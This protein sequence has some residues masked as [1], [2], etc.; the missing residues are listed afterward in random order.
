M[1]HFPIS[2]DAL[3]LLNHGTEAS[4]PE[5]LSED[6]LIVTPSQMNGSPECPTLDP[7][8]CPST[9]LIRPST[10]EAQAQRFESG[11]EDIEFQPISD[12]EEELVEE[13]SSK[14][15]DHHSE[16]LHM[17]ETGDQLDFLEKNCI[18]EVSSFISEKLPSFPSV[19]PE[20]AKQV[21]INESSKAEEAVNLCIVASISN[22]AELNCKTSPDPSNSPLAIDH[23]YAVSL[24]S[25]SE[26][27][28]VKDVKVSSP[29]ED[30]YEEDF[31]SFE[32]S[33]SKGEH[34][35]SEP[36]SHISAL[37]KH[38]PSRVYDSQ[39]K[40]T[41]EEIAEE[42]SQYSGSCEDSHKSG[43]LLYLHN[44]TEDSK[45]D[46]KDTANSIHSPPVSVLQ[47]SFSPVMDEMVS[48]NVGDRVLVGG[49]Q[50]GT[51][52]FKGPASF[53]N[54]FWAGVELDKSEGS[55]NGTY[56]GVVYFACDKNHGIFAPPDKIS[57]LPDR[58][59][60]YTDTTEDEELFFDDLPGK[61][62]EKHQ[63]LEEKSQR[64]GHLKSV[65]EQSSLEI[66]VSGINNVSGESV[67]QSGSHHN[68]LGTFADT[69]LKDFVQDTVNQFA[70]L[71]K[72][73]EQK[74][75]AAN[76]QMN[77]DVFGEYVQ[78]REDSSVEQ[79]DGLPFFL[80][81]EQE[82]RSSP[83]LCNQTVSVFLKII[84]MVNR[85]NMYSTFSVP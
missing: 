26:E 62:G 80:P 32:Y 11:D 23:S 65:N 6:R 53:A 8:S 38:S 72:A 13:I 46:T 3:P 16:H 52:R 41:E 27:P 73:K 24:A 42:L 15:K 43:R 68:L 47:T 17:L 75:E 4:V 7:R 51:L 12:I 33:S 14:S 77:K 79:K 1:Q 71:K 64:E 63:T 70:E 45:H 22:S 56:D 19:S 35:S 37:S 83:E 48:F 9:G 67:R 30:E 18:K 20:D 59:E 36:D 76:L 25:S 81:A 21:K 40:E 74:I 58:F 54:G 55:N 60:I 84:G 50:P 78:E 82:E 66:D 49:V 10:M 5:K 57:H 2:T 85:L 44:K 69:L 28:P 29:I 61:S 39:D 34:H 31:D